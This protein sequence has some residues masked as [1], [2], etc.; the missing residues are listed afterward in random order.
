M[1][2]SSY[3]LCAILCLLFSTV[4]VLAQNGSSAGSTPANSSVTTGGNVGQATQGNST[5]PA[6]SQG[7][8]PN[9]G[10]SATTPEVAAGNA[11]GDENAPGGSTDY[12]NRPNKQNNAGNWG[13]L[14]LL[15]LVGLLGNRLRA[16]TRKHDH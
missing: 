7:G 8:T 16:D 15:G 11:S 5:D 9:A 6:V 13:L 10:H 12:T 4:T 2:H 3:S 14:G 1:K